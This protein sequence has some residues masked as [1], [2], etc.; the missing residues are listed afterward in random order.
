MLPLA[1]V[2]S[3]AA[4]PSPAELNE[5]FARGVR[6][7][8]EA[9]VADALLEFEA[10]EALKPNPVVRFNL[11]HCHAR[12]GHAVRAVALLEPLSTEPSLAP[13]RREAAARL[14]A[15][16]RARIATLALTGDAP[17]GVLELDG[18]T[19]RTALPTSLAVDPGTHNVVFQ[20]PG[21]LPARQVVTVGPGVTLTVALPLVKSERPP[22]RVRLTCAVPGVELLVDGQRLAVTPAPTALQLPA[23]A[24]ALEARRPGYRPWR[25]D[26]V[27]AEGADEQLT[28]E[29]EP[30]PTA[31]DSLV[32]TPSEPQSVVRVDGR[33][34]RP[35]LVLPLP[36]GPHVVEVERDGF[37]PMRRELALAG[38]QRLAVVL[39]PRPETLAALAQRRTAHRLWGV[40][41]VSVGG[42]AVLAG[43]LVWGLNQP[44]LD[45]AQREYDGFASSCDQAGMREGRCDETGLRV[46]AARLVVPQSVR[47]GGVL[48][49]GGGAL[50]AAAGGLALL[51]APDLSRYEAPPHSDALE[52]R[53]SLELGPARV[54]LTVRF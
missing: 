50:V 24:H 13:P 52:P 10:L 3:L 31:T 9:R 6:L 17:D 28:V 44:T 51:T 47:L 38:A 48:A 12:L 8:E 40:L 30:D 53:L 49:L 7:F 46:S 19:T 45:A 26:V 37:F 34:V 20:T 11:A 35:D 18:L 41:G 1:L 14:L 23:G 4:A 54:G 36:S 21:S 43:A 22:A 29:L 32:V 2:L 42:A 33:L 5:R 27:L 16:Q 39:E 25:R 15:E